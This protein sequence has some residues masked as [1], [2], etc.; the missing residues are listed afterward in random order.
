[1]KFQTCSTFK[2]KEN[3][4][5]CIRHSIIVVRIAEVYVFDLFTQLVMIYFMNGEREINW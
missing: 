1:M 3:L 4:I 2:V 5:F